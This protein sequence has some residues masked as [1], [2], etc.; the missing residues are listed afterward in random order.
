MPGREAV[1]TTIPIAGRVAVSDPGSSRRS[2]GSSG[3]RSSAALADSLAGLPPPKA[4]E[5][6]GTF[7]RRAAPSPR[8]AARGAPSRRRGEA[9]RWRWLMLCDAVAGAAAWG[10]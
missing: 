8:A 6:E 3:T 2:S 5:P 1:A 9:M 10:A 4:K 7:T